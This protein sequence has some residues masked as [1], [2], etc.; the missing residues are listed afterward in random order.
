MTLSFKSCGSAIAASLIALALPCSTPAAAAPS[1]PARAAIPLLATPDQIEAERL[2]RDLLKDPALKTEQA[3]IRAYLAQT[4]IGQTR[5]GAARL[6]EVVAQW[7]NSL[8]FKELLKGRSTPV[9]LW[10]TDDTPRTW[11]G[12]TLGGVGT[13][14]DNPDHIYRSTNIDGSGRYEITGKFDPAT[15]PAQFVLSVAPAVEFHQQPLSKNRADLGQQIALLSDK[16]LKIE[17][18]GSF[19]VTLGGPAPAGDDNHIALPTGPIGVGFRDVLSDW[20][21]RAAS[22]QI[23]R[24]DA[25]NAPPFDAAALRARV[26]A[27][28]EP[29]VR[30]WASYPELWFGGLAPNTVAPPVARDGGWGYLSAVRFQLQPDE[31]ILVKISRGGAQYNGIQIVDPWMIASDARRYQTSLNPS[32][33]TADADGNYSFII[34]PHDPGVANWLDSNGLHDGFAVLRWQNMPKDATGEGLI[35]DF[36]VIKLKDAGSLPGVAPITPQQRKAQLLK[37]AAGYGSRTQ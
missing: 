13:S 17:A 19:R 28:L 31:A 20:D 8:I 23:R 4:T 1:A 5:D 25:V 33:A 7:T 27:N 2:L 34:A 29:Y 3:R 9:I 11:L 21:Q 30:F 12:Y 24:L 14:G 35:R 10:G 18:D 36:R 26:L 32:Q 6:D 15:R 22:L 16:D 37:R